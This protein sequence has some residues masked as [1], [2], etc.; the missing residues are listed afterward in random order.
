VIKEGEVKLKQCQRYNI[1]SVG[2]VDSDENKLLH[3]S[4][5]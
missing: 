5:K 4:R 1:I 3:I 2:V